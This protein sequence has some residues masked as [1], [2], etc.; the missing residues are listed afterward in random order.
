[1]F[2]DRT[3]VVFV[4]LIL[5]VSMITFQAC[6]SKLEPIREYDR[7]VSFGRKCLDSL[8]SL[9]FQGRRAGTVG[10]QLAF[11][12]IKQLICEMGFEP[13]TQLF[14]TEN[15]TELHNLIVTIL[16]GSDST[17]VVG[18]HYDG[19]VESCDGDHYQAAE[20]NAS[21]TTALLILLNNLRIQS[22]SKDRTIVCCF[23]DG[24]EVLEGRPFR[25]SSHFVN[26]LPSSVVGRILHYQNLDTIGHD[27]E[28]VLYVEYLGNKRV[29][30]AVY[31]ISSNDRF[32]Y[33]VNK[34]TFFN[35]DYTPFSQAGIPFINYHDHMTSGCTHPNHSVKDTKDVISIKR[36]EKIVCNVLDCIDYY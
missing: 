23:W 26:S 31:T 10:N 16:G 22:I 21:G 33:H 18:A 8:C 13:E 2:L 6:S 1:M 29:E 34:S 28:N 20:D 25:G 15:G 12:Y 11:E 32:E 9:T 4:S 5:F 24:E 36:L 14:Y 30:E 35:S 17:V 19:A 27:H 3:K 7:E